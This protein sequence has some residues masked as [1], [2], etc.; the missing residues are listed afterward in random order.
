MK[1]CRT[2]RGG[3]ALFENTKP[4]IIEVEWRNEMRKDDTTGWAV[5]QL[6]LKNTSQIQSNKMKDSK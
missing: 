1:R 4:I 3:K 5:H 2:K 6:G